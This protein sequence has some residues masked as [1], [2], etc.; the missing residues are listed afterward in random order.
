MTVETTLA[1]T[2]QD[3]RSFSAKVEEA[4]WMADFRSKL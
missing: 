3:V 1:L 4:A 2:E